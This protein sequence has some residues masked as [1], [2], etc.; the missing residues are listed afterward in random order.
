[1]ILNNIGFGIMTA[2]AITFY[3]LWR[4]AETKLEQSKHSRELMA[5]AIDGL[6]KFRQEAMAA[7]EVKVRDL[8]G[9]PQPMFEAYRM[10]NGIHLPIKEFKYRRGDAGDKEYKRICAEEFAEKCNEEP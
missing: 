7:T 1:M 4:R 10:C 3:G 8:H 9:I 6:K 2:A 5:S